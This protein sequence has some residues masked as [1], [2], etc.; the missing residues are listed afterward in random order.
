[1]KARTAAV[2]AAGL[3]G[4]LVVGFA[5]SAMA[6]GDPA[7]DTTRRTISVSST[8]TVTRAP[9]EA[10]VN[11][12]VRSEDPEGAVAFAQNARDMK[13]VVDA[14]KATGIAERDLRT[15]N[16]G[17]SQ[18]TEDR[19]TAT[20][21]QVFVA[22][23]SLEVTVKDLDTVGEV[24]DA[25]VRAG[26]DSVNDINF[27]LSDPVAMRMSALRE[28]VEGARAKANAM[29]SAAGAQVVGVTTI[30]EGSARMPVRRA[31][32]NYGLASTEAALTPVIAPKNLEASVTVQVVWEIG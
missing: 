15:L 7:T 14:L 27:Q 12:G 4:V 17:L 13:A 2:V 23:N 8:A 29:A 5:A 22:T 21:H 32:Y 16:V 24:I 18:H 31:V 20:E 28:A 6:G 3:V 1:M 25:A 9:D 30:R 19:G 11:L 10:V 26:V